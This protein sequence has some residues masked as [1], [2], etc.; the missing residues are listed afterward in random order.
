[1]SIVVVLLFERSR[2]AGALSSRKGAADVPEPPLV[3]PGLKPEE[4]EHRL[5]KT[6]V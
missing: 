3:A 5:E 2:L 6:P 1:V 4:I